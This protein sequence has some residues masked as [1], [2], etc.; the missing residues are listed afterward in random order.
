MSRA[1][2]TCSQ[3]TLFLCGQPDDEP[4]GRPDV[5]LTADNARRYHIHPER[6]KGYNSSKIAQH[7]FDVGVWAGVVSVLSSTINMCE[8]NP[9]SPIRT[10]HLK[11]A[12]HACVRDFGMVDPVRPKERRK[13]GMEWKNRMMRSRGRPGGFLEGLMWKSSLASAVG[14]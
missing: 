2:S 11:L 6:S 9:R 8:V 12:A 3:G 10:R 1:N 4:E 14:A 5:H 7:A 13:D